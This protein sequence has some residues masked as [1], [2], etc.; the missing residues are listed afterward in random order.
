MKEKITCS[1]LQLNFTLKVTLKHFLYTRKKTDKNQV[2]YCLAEKK[3]ILISQSFINKY[4]Q[5]SNNSLINQFFTSL[6]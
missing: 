2:K 4:G 5:S 3:S 1:N 6:I